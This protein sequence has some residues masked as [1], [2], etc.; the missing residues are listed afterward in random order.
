MEK[1]L[2]IVIIGAG[3]TGLSTAH[4][5]LSQAKG[6]QRVTV[7]EQATVDHERS[8]SHGFSRLLRFEYGSDLFYTNMVRLS[9]ARWRQLER[10]TGRELYTRSGVVTLGKKDD[11]CTVTSYRLMRS[12]GLPVEQMQEGE[13]RQRFPQFATSAF[14]SFIYNAEGGIL[15]ASSCL[16]VLRDRIRDMGGEIRE[17]SRVT[18]LEHDRMNRPV[19]LRFASG[20]ALEAN[21]VIV[22]AGPWVHHV[23]A[24]LKLPVRV[25]RQYLL[26][27]AGLSPSLFAAGRFPAFLADT[28]YGFPIHRGCNGWV[29]VASHDPGATISPDDTTPPDRAV[30]TR[31]RHQLYELLP[32]LRAAEVARVDSC[33]YDMSPD[34]D[35]ILDRLLNDPRVVVATGLSGHGFKFGLLLGEVL[36]SMVCET[37]PVIPIERFGLNR[38]A[39]TPQ[40][41]QS[42]AF[43]AP[44]SGVSR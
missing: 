28:L 44:L 20:E 26:Y 18:H 7:L 25:T 12:V 43:S 19:Q 1:P 5:L 15:H 42:A 31:I 2:H 36:S 10:T 29:K 32:E 34:G 23:L 4:A 13:F 6:Q 37:E 11:R 3:I 40:W 8:T 21:R 38:F 39:V 30:L 9:L 22:A 33:M 41:V 16:Q 24:D 14:D 35:F 17:N 27:F